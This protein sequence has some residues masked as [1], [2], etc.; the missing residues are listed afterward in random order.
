METDEADRAPRLRHYLR[1]WREHMDNGK[2][3][4]QEELAA[5]TGIHK[6]IISRI[7]TGKHG[8]ELEL[9]FKLTEALGILPGQLFQHPDRPSLDFITR[10]DSDEDVAK[11]ADLVNGM[12][13]MRR[14]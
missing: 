7:E 13:A 10:N 6:S 14:G 4:K 2:G 11:I 8:I 5:R 1:Q 9:L 3:W 12:R